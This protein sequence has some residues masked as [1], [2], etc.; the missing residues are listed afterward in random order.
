MTEAKRKPVNYDQLYPGRFIKA[1]EFNGKKVTLTIADVDTEKLQGDD[2]KE[3]TKAILAFREIDRKHVCCK[4]NGLC[5]K[6]MFGAILKDW[7]GKRVVFF[8]DTWN[9][10]PAI[11]IW[12]SPDIE[13][14][15][16]VM[17]TLPRRKPFKK[18]MHATGKT[19]HQQEPAREDAAERDSEPNEADLVG[20][21]A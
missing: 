21:G 14:D 13:R 17:V 10:E 12:G 9:G 8:P 2:G 3:Q 5:M 20:E 19:T 15:V 7:I 6:A 11:R 16:D 1:G 4:T 18:T